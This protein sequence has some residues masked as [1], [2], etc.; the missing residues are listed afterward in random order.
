MSK[1]VYI[2][3]NPNYSRT[4]WDETGATNYV[5]GNRVSYDDGTNDLI[6]VCLVDNNSTTTPNNDSTNWVAAGSKD[7]PFQTKGI[8]AFAGNSPNGFP[9]T[10]SGQ[11]E[12]SLNQ[13]DTSRQNKTAYPNQ[14]TNFA[15]D[16]AGPGGTIIFGDGDYATPTGASGNSFAASNVTLKSLNFQKATLLTPYG[17]LVNGNKGPGESNGP[18]VIEDFVQYRTF[19]GSGPT[20]SDATNT[21]TFRDCYITDQHPQSTYQNDA[22]S[23]TSNGG[24]VGGI[25]NEFNFFYNCSIIHKRYYVNQLSYNTIGNAENCTFYI[26]VA[27]GNTGY[28][29]FSFHSSANSLN[30]KNCIVYVKHFYKN[31]STNAFFGDTTKESLDGVCWFVENNYSGKEIQSGSTVSYSDDL[32]SNIDPLFIDAENNNYT[33]RPASPLIGGLKSKNPLSNKYPE[34]MWFDANHTPVSLT[35]NFSLDSGD[36]NNYTFSGDATGTDP[37][38]TAGTGDTLIFTNNTGSHPIG[39]ED[40]DGNV[41]AIESNGTLSFS[42]LREGTY[43]YVCQAPHPN[44]SNTITITRK[45]GSYDNPSNNFLAALGVSYTLLIKNGT[46][47]LTQKV[48]NLPEAD[49]KIIGESAEK[50]VLVFTGGGY[51]GAIDAAYNGNSSSLSF[52]SLTFLWNGSA[53]C[54]GII[55]SNDLNIKSCIFSQTQAHLNG[56]STTRG[57]FAGRKNAGNTAVIQNSI[58]RGR[59]DNALVFGG[60]YN[61]NGFNKATISSC[62]VICDGEVVKGIYGGASNTV[63]LSSP[64]SFTLKNTLHVGFNGTESLNSVA[65]SLGGSNYYYN[66][67]LSTGF[68]DGD[69]VSTEPPGFISESD[70]RLRPN[71]RLIGGTDMPF[72]GA[73]W[74]TNTAGTGGAGTYDDP[75]NFGSL[76]DAIAA[77]GPNGDIV[78]KNGAY[79]NTSLGNFVFND[80]STTTNQVNFHAETPGK[81]EFTTTGQIKF[82]DSTY[83]PSSAA[84]YNNLIFTSTSTGNDIVTFNQ[85]DT[86]T[87]IKH[88]FFG[89]KFKA[90]T[91]MENLGMTT[92]ARVKFTG[93]TF[94][95]TGTTYGFEQRNGTT[96]YITVFFKNCL[97]HNYEASSAGTNPVP[98]RRCG[99][100]TLD[101]TIVVDYFN[102]STVVSIGHYSLNII[103]SNF[104]LGNGTKMGNDSEN[105]GVDP[106]FIDP[107]KGNFQLRPNSP[108][109]G[110]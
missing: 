102:L 27:Y 71:S 32:V 10:G 1:T 88:S 98:L 8:L 34:G 51:G 35:Y 84:S 6:F 78:F 22:T 89:C 36:G 101:S 33:L 9:S 39:I 14:P 17:F 45:V 46:H 20:N 83:S 13:W 28:S 54:Y 94:S 87:E 69:L 40:P 29:L 11:G 24:N 103:N 97:I 30:L 41:I 91:F 15:Y 63:G 85:L 67:G 61:Q 21:V 95:Y 53:N 23:N 50:S 110:K 107:S 48:I 19:S 4:V 86:D 37:A 59:S 96:D 73:I 52:E 90:R 75:F 76:T 92:C 62:T 42:T 82:G 81:V 106:K 64:Q 18:L 38:I 72:P 79:A 57:W 66:M 2:E 58:I 25:L 80:V 70:P 31:L 105:F 12:L 77:A 43:R 68:L 109:I 26:Q 100:L 74:V 104:I 3:I 93:C 16:A 60:D 56:S 108:L 5:A 65:P 55:L 47:T 44:M 7:F 99:A 49:L